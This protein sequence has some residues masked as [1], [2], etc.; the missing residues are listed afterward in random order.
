VIGSGFAGV[1]FVVLGH[2][3]NIAWGATRNVLDVT[4]TFLETIV[5]DD[6]SPSGLSIVHLGQLEPI[7]PIPEL[8]R[9]NGLGNG[10][11][12]DFT[13]V[14]GVTLIVPRR[15]QGPIVELDLAQ[16]VGLSIQYV[17]FSPTREL[18]TFRMW[19]EAQNLDAFQRG[20]DFFDVGSQNF[21][22]IDVRGNIA[23][24]MS[25]EVPLREDLQQS[26]VNGL[27]P[28]FIR[29]GSGGNEWIPV[30]KQRKDQALPFEILP[31][32]E[33]PQLVNPP[34]GFFVSAN[35]DPTGAT[36]DNDPLNQ[37]RPGGGILYLSPGYV[38]YRAGRI[39]QLIRAKLAGGGKISFADMQQMQADTVM[40]D[41]QFFVPHILAAFTRAETSPNPSLNALALDPGVAEAVG[42]LRSWDFSTPTG[43]PQ[44]YDASDVD[45]ALSLPSASEEAASVAATIYAVWR[46]RFIANTV[47]AVLG[48]LPRPNG[49]L[50]VSALRHLLDTFDSTGGVGASGIPFFGVGAPPEESRDIAILGSLAQALAALAGP[51]FANAFGSADQRDYR[52]GRLHRLVMRHPLDDLLSVPPA[53]GL[54]PHPLGEGLPGI[55]VDGGFE[56]VDDAAH[57]ARAAGEN[58]F[59]YPTAVPAPGHR[60]VAEAGPNGIRAVTSLPGG[61]S[62]VLGPLALNLLPSYLTNEAFPLWF[63]A[64][65]VAEHAAS[66]VRFVPAH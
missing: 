48:P 65:E 40:I 33:M 51:A 58:Q 47:D 20:L 46:S 60:F 2:N 41:A 52:W 61:V 5:P 34:A 45:G 35:N 59:M 32:E 57:D 18:D 50:A 16:G 53:G 36:L 4:D 62:G 11:A 26:T 3:N 44:G 23:M 21:S 37:L 31:A 1:P 24:F 8:F 7:I 14:S 42:R 10:I 13:E 6:A 17:G 29:N 54:F 49:E 28:F 15:N 64:S 55:P 63:R 19:N 56:T 12:D 39:T 25:G 38:G 66:I 9:V 43:I 27:P 30:Q 22:Y